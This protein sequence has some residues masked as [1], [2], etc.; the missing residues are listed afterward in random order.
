MN[1]DFFNHPSLSAKKHCPYYNSGEYTVSLT[2]FSDSEPVTTTQEIEIIITGLVE[3]NVSNFRIYPN[4]AKANLTLEGI[5]SRGLQEFTTATLFSPDGKTVATFNLNGS[6]K[7]VL[8]L[9][10]R[11]ESGIY[12]ISLRGERLTEIKRFVI[13]K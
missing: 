3:E 4:P 8:Q 1:S 13:L 9:P 7:Q 12:F 10:A 2:A 5:S 6:D 11:L